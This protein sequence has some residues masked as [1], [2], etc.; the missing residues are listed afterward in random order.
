VAYNAV[1]SKVCEHKSNLVAIGVVQA[2]SRNMN[3]GQLAI[4]QNGAGAWSSSS[5]DTDKDY[6]PGGLEHY[7]SVLNYSN[8]EFT[9]NYEEPFGDLFS[10]ANETAERYAEIA[11]NMDFYAFSREGAISDVLDNFREAE[12]YVDTQI[13]IFI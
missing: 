5:V 11:F 7:T 3:N 8:T 10:K 4:L 13:G 9:A 12:K 6:L 2:A 1:F